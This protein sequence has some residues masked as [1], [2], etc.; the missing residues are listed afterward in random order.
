MHRVLWC[1]MVYIPN[2][3]AVVVRFR[4]LPL[5]FKAPMFLPPQLSAYGA[6]RKAS[7]QVSK[8]ECRRPSP[9]P[10]N[11]KRKLKDLQGN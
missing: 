10:L 11:E 4:D 1:G 8:H 3:P 5:F 9:S 7:K 2:Q 6:R